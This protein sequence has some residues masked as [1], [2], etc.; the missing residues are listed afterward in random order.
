M[1]IRMTTEVRKEAVLEAA[2]LVAQKIGFNKMRACD[3]AEKAECSHGLVFARW[4]T[5]GQ[6]RR[7]VMRAAIQRRVLS[8]VAEGLALGDKDARKAPDDLKKAALASL[9]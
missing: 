5:L 2:L 6:L 9:G 8:I 7:A 3:I 4:T 1:A